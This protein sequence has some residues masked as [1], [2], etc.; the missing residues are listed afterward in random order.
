[1]KKQKRS[2]ALSILL[3]SGFMAAAA[4][5]H[6]DET[7]ADASTRHTEAPPASP[8]HTEADAPMSSQAKS[9]GLIEDSHFNLLLRSY[10]EHDDLKGSGKKDASVLGAQAVFESGYTKGLIGLGGDVSLFGAFKF[11]GGE[12]AGNRVHLGTDGGGSG[13][14]AWAYPGVWDVKARVSNTV[15]KYG[16]QLFDDPFLVPHD[17]RSLPPTYRGFS[18][19]SDEI[20]GLT[21]KAGTVDAVLARGM[22]SV[23]GLTTEYGGTHI[24]RFSF[25]G[26][27]WTHGDDTAFSLWGGIANDVWQQYYLN[28]THSIG[29]PASIRW[30]GALNYYYTGSIGDQRQGAIT[31]NA[32]S[33]ALSGT[34]GAH[35]VQV[36]YQQIVSD[37]RFDY[38]GQSAGDYLSNSL[39]VDYNQPHEKSLSLTYTLDMKHYGVPGLKVAVWGA[40]GWDADGSAMANGTSA[41]AAAYRING[42]P[43]QGTHYEVG[44]IPSYTVPSGKLKNTSIKFY[45]MHH[46]S[47]SPYYPDGT[48]DVYRLMVNVPV[49]VF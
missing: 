12:G 11:N 42:T 15:L 45:Y 1:M 41:Q 43:I 37:Q 39:D 35:T 26:G 32:Y 8:P 38:M 3:C 34:H 23:T 19:E 29:D 27:D 30:T 31:N 20:R 16:Q 49:N 9:N 4:T 10:T 2:I 21:L 44:V 14:L 17:N 25:F 24:S 5:S 48:S 33:L 28:A 47:N 7:D 13:Q 46:H 18:L 6:A 36:A 40:Y 22:T